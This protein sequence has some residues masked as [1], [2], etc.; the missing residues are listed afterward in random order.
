MI[1]FPDLQ[2][3]LDFNSIALIIDLGGSRR[4]LL[5]LKL[6]YPEVVEELKTLAE[7]ARKDLG[8][9]LTGKN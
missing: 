2:F 4:I 5:M 3:K 6:L 8:D 7:V 1:G 9:D